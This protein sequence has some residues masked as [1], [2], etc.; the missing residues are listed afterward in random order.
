MRKLFISVLL[1]IC[2]FLSS[3]AQTPDSIQSN[4]HKTSLDNK[5][6]YVSVEH[7]LDDFDEAFETEYTKFKLPDKSM[8]IINKPEEV[9]DLELKYVNSEK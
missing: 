7:I 8:V 2:S 3:C 1:I 6:S 9:C 4:N 5:H